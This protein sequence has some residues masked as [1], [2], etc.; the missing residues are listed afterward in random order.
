[1]K[2]YDVTI[3]LYILSILSSHLGNCGSS[4]ENQTNIYFFHNAL[5]YKLIHNFLFL[6]VHTPVI[7]SDSEYIHYIITNSHIYN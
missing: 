7:Y 6:P 5:Y 3:F 2:I 1:M 4:F